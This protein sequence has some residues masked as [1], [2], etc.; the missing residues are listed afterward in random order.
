MEEEE[1]KLNRCR[2][3]AF[4]LHC[5]TLILYMLRVS[6]MEGGMCASQKF[7]LQAAINAFQ[8]VLFYFNRM[9]LRA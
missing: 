6:S 7:R 1:H 3:I 5:F 2:F 8:R 4:K 9:W